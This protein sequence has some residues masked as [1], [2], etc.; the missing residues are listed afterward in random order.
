M[1]PAN[2][3]KQP[4]AGAV[5]WSMNGATTVKNVA[6]PLTHMLHLRA[7]SMTWYPAHRALIRMKHATCL[8]T[9][10][11]SPVGTYLEN[12]DLAF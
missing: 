12:S 9:K 6:D 11:I 5:D 7:C 4:V 2:G 1:L 8:C 3:L 10:M